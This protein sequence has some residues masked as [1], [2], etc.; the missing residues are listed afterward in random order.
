MLSLFSTY[1][2][3]HT[4]IQKHMYV[5]NHGMSN[6]SFVVLLHILLSHFLAGKQSECPKQGSAQ[7]KQKLQRK[8]GKDREGAVAGSTLPFALQCV[9]PVMLPPLFVPSSTALCA[10]AGRRNF[11]C[12]S[13]MLE[14]YF[15]LWLLK[16]ERTVRG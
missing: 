2:H 14:K 5:C 4:Y 10:L 7:S 16:I 12:L 11:S 13:N 1:T 6:V 8:R 3:W 9:C 15:K